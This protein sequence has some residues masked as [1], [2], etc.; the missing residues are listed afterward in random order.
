MNDQH[1]KQLFW[2]CVAV[3]F[4]SFI[5]M[6]ILIYVTFP[7]H[8]RDMANNFQG[9]LQG[10]LMMSAIGFLLTGNIN[11]FQ[12]KPPVQDGTTTAD[13]SISTSTSSEP[14]QDDKN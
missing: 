2:F 6:F 13:I 3:F 14:K 11:S 7:T 10:S 9:F 1:F 5:G 8:S 4:M 12:K